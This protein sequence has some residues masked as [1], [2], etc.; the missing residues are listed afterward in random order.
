VTKEKGAL[1]IPMD[2]TNIQNKSANCFQVA[3]VALSASIF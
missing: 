1:F 3:E 2:G